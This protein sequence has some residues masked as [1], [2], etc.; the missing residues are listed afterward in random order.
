[1][2]TKNQNLS[3]W[4]QYLGRHVLESV[5]STNEYAAQLSALPAWVLAKCQTSGRGRR[6]RDWVSPVGNFYAS[7][8]MKPKGPTSEA[9]L[10]SFIAALAL[11]DSL[12]A[13]GVAA[14]RLALKWPNDVLLDGGKVA[15]I[16]L[17]SGSH[18]A[19]VGHLIIGFGVNLSTAPSKDLVEARALPPVSLQEATGIFVNPEVFLNHLAQ[20]FAAW[21]NCFNQ[22]SFEPIRLAWLAR[23]AH[24]GQVITART[25]HT[26]MRGIF[27]TID[28]GG[29]LLLRQS[30]RFIAISAA[31]VYFDGGDDA[32]CN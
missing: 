25:G 20:A 21:E 32:A 2:S 11:Y 12:V 30:N 6:G 16:L 27:D 3:D 7:Y 15:G 4:P 8:I 31:D 22:G 18:G 17:E 28:A 9:A 29:A 26:E 5:P 1:M 23:A 14:E 10:R 24:L 13:L 19:G